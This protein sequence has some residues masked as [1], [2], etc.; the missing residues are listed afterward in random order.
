MKR[1]EMAKL[2][3]GA[4][5]SASSMKLIAGQAYSRKH[6]PKGPISTTNL[7]DLRGG[8][9]RR[10]LD[11]TYFAGRAGQAYRAAS[12]IPNVLDHLYCYCECEVSVGH[13]SLKSCFVD[14]HGANCGICQ[15]QA[16]M[17]WR[18]K[19]RGLP[20]LEIRHKVDR[21]FLTRARRQSG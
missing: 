14:L 1:R 2:I 3:V 16:L 4:L 19:Q 17:A 20:I 13:K 10:I 5:L 21:V 6:T 9:T 18:L 15:E 8:E 12:E 11:G 7:R